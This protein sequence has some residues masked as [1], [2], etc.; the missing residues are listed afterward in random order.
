MGLLSDALLQR[1]GQLDGQSMQVA[2]VS[3]RS[4]DDVSNGDPD[5]FGDF[6]RTQQVV[7]C[8]CMDIKPG[9][10]LRF[11]TI[12]VPLPLP[13]DGHAV[14][15]LDYTHSKEPARPAT[16]LAFAFCLGSCGTG[17]RPYVT[18]SNRNRPGAT[19]AAARRI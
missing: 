4:K 5:P 2:A 9:F 16:G 19:P 11:F 13:R 7:P 15:K 1:L 8:P 10:S 18:L 14:R 17:T 12:D 3:G 6:A